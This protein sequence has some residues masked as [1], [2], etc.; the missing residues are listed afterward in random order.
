MKRKVETLI[1]RLRVSAVN[2][3]QEMGT[4]KTLMEEVNRE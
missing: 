4:V 1:M 3:Y 2:V